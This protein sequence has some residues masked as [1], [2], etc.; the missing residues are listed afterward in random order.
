MAHEHFAVSPDWRWYILLY[1]FLA[2]IA[3]GAYVIG[4]LLRFTGRDPAASRPRPRRGWSRAP[5][6]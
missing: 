6:R 3:G 2:G 5:C 1:F 4:A